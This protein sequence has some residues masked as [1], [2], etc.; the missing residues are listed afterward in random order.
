MIVFCSGKP[1]KFSNQFPADFL[2]GRV[3][4]AIHQLERILLQ[5]IKLIKI[6]TVEHVF[7]AMVEDSPLG[8]IEF[9]SIQLREQVSAPVVGNLVIEKWCQATS[10]MVLLALN[11]C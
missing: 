10:G 1:P 6:K 2:I 5:V 11:S 9:N 7:V 4:Y 3:V 8:V